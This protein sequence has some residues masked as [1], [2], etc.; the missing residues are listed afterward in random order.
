MVNNIERRDK[1]SLVDSKIIEIN[2]E[3]YERYVLKTHKPVILDFYSDDCVPCEALAPK[4]EDLAYYFGDDIKFLKIWRQKNR[5]LAQ[6]LGVFSSPTLIF[7]KPYGVEVGK[8]LNGLIKK[9]DI[10]EQI[11]ILIGPERVEKILLKKQKQR[12]D[13]D[14]IVLGAGPAGLT[15]ALYTAQAKLNTLVIDEDLPGGQIKITHQVSNYPGTGEPISGWELSERMQKQ[16]KLAGAKIFA[17]VDVTK[18]DLKIGDHTV[19]IDDEIEVHGKVLVMATGARPKNLNIPGEKEYK[20]KGISYCATCDGKYYEGL[21]VV[22]IGG[23][24][25]AVEES[26]FLTKFVNKVTIVHQFDH[27]QANKTAQEEAFKN[28]KI[29]FVWNSEPRKIEKL[30]N[31]K[32]KITIQNVK[33]HEYSEILTDGIFVFMGYEPNIEVIKADFDK[34]PWGY[35]KTNEDMAT[36][37]EGVYVVGDLRSKKYRQATIAVGEGTIAAM[38][39]EKYLAELKHTLKTQKNEF[40]LTK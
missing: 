27:L 9:K 36:H 11:K 6:K 5:S 31:G 8:R 10:I 30:P 34:D 29:N 32:M 13:V 26:L 23:G 24:N 21:D 39:I 3:Q 35:I 20:G 38:A 18:V 12:I 16:V 14:V 40:V 19:W 1:M 2:E 28:P 33:T 17:A 25:S 15:T 22:V 4:F 7:Y 37:I